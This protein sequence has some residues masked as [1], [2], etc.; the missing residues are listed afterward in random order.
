MVTVV[1]EPGEWT[2]P[3]KV[4]GTELQQKGV[5]P[6]VAEQIMRAAGAEPLVPF[7]GSNKPWLCIHLECGEQIAPI[8]NNVRRRGTM[9]RGCGA[10]RRGAARRAKLAEAAVKEM[11]AG[12][13]EPLEP[14]PGTGKP[15]RC[16][17]IQ[18]G[19]E[20]TPTLN[21]IRANGTACRPCSLRRLG[22][23]VWTTESAVEFFKAHN[24]EPLEPYPGSSAKPWKARHT[25]CGRI[26]SPRLGNVAAGQGACRDCGQE[27]SHRATRLEEAEVVAVMRQAGLEPLDPYPG[28]DAP[29]RCRH[30]PCGREVSPRYFNVKR[31][32]GGCATCAAAA[33]SARL[34][35]PE[36]DARAI[37]ATAGLEP[38]EPYPGSGRPWKSRHTCGKIAYPTLSN[39]RAGKG[40]CRYCYSAFPYDGPA[41]VYLVADHHALKIGCAARH[42][43]R[44]ATH[45][46]YG[47]THAWSIDLTTGDEAYNVEQAILDWW[48][49]D[50]GIPATYAPSQMPQ[51]G[52]T[53]TAS[54]EEATPSE[55]LT[56]ALEILEELGIGLVQ[57]H[58][59]ESVDSRPTRI[60]HGGGAKPRRNIDPSRTCGQTTLL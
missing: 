52:F 51:E 32:Q 37:M 3:I 57:L 24:L 20:R 54:W 4:R 45:L 60:A 40:I 30:E 22:F 35:M 1:S 6:A 29:W 55:T 53:E 26:V 47:W 58:A 49:N 50:L 31:G 44:V 59:A 16:R 2:H 8:F 36:P 46:R 17:H 12:G 27:A 7:P 28:V 9:C 21:S 10:K 38:V 48:R 13:F 56:R 18:C 19:E 43:D 23:E 15:W 34:L 14:Y 41:M 25:V 11:L 42:G 5:L 39:V 33:A